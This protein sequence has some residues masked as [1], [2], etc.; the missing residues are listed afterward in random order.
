MGLVVIRPG[1]FVPSDLFPNLPDGGAGWELI[2]YN[3]GSVLEANGDALGFENAT[4]WSQHPENQ[5]VVTDATNPSGSGQALEITWVPAD[6]GAG[7]M[8]IN[9]FAGGPYSELY[10]AYGL[11]IESTGANWPFGHKW[12]YLMTE[13]QGSWGGGIWTEHRNDDTVRIVDGS[14]DVSSTPTVFEARDEPMLC[15]WLYQITGSGTFDA[16]VYKDGNATPVLTMTG[17]DSGGTG[18]FTGYHM[19]NHTSDD[20]GSDVSVQRYQYIAL[21]G[22]V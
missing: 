2:G 20:M 1:A 13:G 17:A 22:K 5:E 16:A 12:Y 21:Y 10:I 15:E 7:V 14:D 19:Y 18:G 9:S 11:V 4:G 6:G 8:A 3:D